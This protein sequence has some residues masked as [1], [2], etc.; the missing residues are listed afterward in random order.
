MQDVVLPEEISPGWQLVDGGSRGKAPTAELTAALARNRS[1]EGI[2]LV[3][4]ASISYLDFLRN[5]VHHL[6]LLDVDNF[7]IGGPLPKVPHL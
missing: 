3:T 4:W 6:S 7:I 5:W 1:R 2:V